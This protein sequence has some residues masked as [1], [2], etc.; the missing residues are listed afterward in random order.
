MPLMQTV[1]V[2]NNVKSFM[3]GR[4]VYRKP[5]CIKHFM[6]LGDKADAARRPP[7]CPA[8]LPRPSAP[9]VCPAC[10]R[11]VPRSGPAECPR[12]AFSAPA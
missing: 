1:L 11:S 3:A 10:V 7:V 5:S 9:P 6:Y 4:L 2:S 8:R 12:P